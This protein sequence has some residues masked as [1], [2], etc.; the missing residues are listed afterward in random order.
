MYRSS[1]LRLRPSS[2]IEQIWILIFMPDIFKRLASKTT[3][4]PPSIPHTSHMFSFTL[5][6][7]PSVVAF[8]L[9]RTWLS[10][11]VSDKVTVR[12]QNGIA[13]SRRCDDHAKG[14]KLANFVEKTKRAGEE[15]HDDYPDR[16]FKDEEKRVDSLTRLDIDIEAQSY[17]IRV[18]IANWTVVDS[19]FSSL[20]FKSRVL[21]HVI[22]L[23]SS[24]ASRVTLTIFLTDLMCASI[25]L[26]TPISVS[27]FFILFHSDAKANCQETRASWHS[28]DA[29]WRCVIGRFSFACISL[30]PPLPSTQ[31]SC[32]KI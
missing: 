5:S 9:P 8:P 1:L 13:I 29:A 12:R 15:S 7:G 21:A 17:R 18:G 4:G 24:I 20:V 32:N 23:L 2:S 31:P 22:S 26:R 16:D 11:L 14:N 19:T 28:Y 27:I 3:L 30:P 10:S 6:S 25:L